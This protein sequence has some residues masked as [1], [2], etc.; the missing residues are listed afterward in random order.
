MMAQSAQSVKI[1]TGEQNT[2]ITFLDV[3]MYDGRSNNLVSYKKFR[4]FW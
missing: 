3:Y 2:Q 4:V 1:T